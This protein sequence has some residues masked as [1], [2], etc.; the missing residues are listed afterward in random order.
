MDITFKYKVVYSSRRTLAI[1]IRPDGSVIVRV[2]YRTTEKTIAKLVNDKADWIIKHTGNL[3]KDALNNPPRLYTDGEKHLLRGTECLLRIN[4]SA[5]SYCTFSLNAIELGI[6]AP[7]NRDAV[8]RVLYSG[9]RKEANKLFNKTLIQV[10]SENA[11]YGFKISK[12]KVRTMKSRWGSCS[13]RGVITLNTE[14]IRLPDRFTRYVILHEL[15]H[16][17]HHNHG[18]RFYALLTE[19][20]PEWRV[21]RKELRGYVLGR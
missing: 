6:Q 20:D 19:L 8:R 2:P 18:A 4:K 12:L 13:G 17:R 10:L 1:S 9:Y 7:E 14:L 11:S 21:V 5:K 15:C 16:L 3:R